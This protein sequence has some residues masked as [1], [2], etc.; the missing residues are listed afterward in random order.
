MATQKGGKKNRKLGRNKRACD[1]YKAGMRQYTNKIKRIQR[2]VRLLDKRMAKLIE[3]T[4]EWDRALRHDDTLASQ[5][6]SVNQRMANE[7]GRK[8]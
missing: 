7:F 2:E 1:M 3:F 8:K 6:K 5:L 4:S